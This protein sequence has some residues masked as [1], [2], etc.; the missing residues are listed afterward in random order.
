MEA[1]KENQRLE[2]EAQR[3]AMEEKTKTEAK[4][5]AMISV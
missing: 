1:E 2:M 5:D 3:L 4:V